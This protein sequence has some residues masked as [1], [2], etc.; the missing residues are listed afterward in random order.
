MGRFIAH[1]CKVLWLLGLVCLFAC[2]PACGQALPSVPPTGIVKE[3]T[4]TSLP[5]PATTTPAGS[6]TPTQ[7]PTPSS[8]LE[9]NAEDLR[10]T[11]I[12]Y[13]H[14][15]SGPAG[16]TMQELVDE[17]NLNNEWRIVVVPVFQDGLERMS[18]SLETALQSGDAP[19]LAMGYLYQALA[20][21]VNQ[22]L[23]DQQIYVD[24][25][26]WGFSLDEQADFY[27]AFWDQD[28]SDGKR[29][30][31]PA[32][33]SG[34]LLYYNQSWAKELGFSF[35]P[36]LPTQ[37]RE[38]ACKAA[39]ANRQ[40]RDPANDG[41]GG[42][43]VS[44]NYAAMLG[45]IYAFGGEILKEPEP[46]LEQSVYQ[47]NSPQNVQTFTFLRE[48]YDDGCAWVA[49]SEFPNAEFASRK[50]LFATD[51][52]LGIPYQVDAFASAGNQ[53]QWTVIPFPSPSQEPAIDVYGPSYVILSSSPERQLAAWLFIK[54]LLLPQ[55]QA[56]IVEASGAFP[57]RAS[58]LSYLEGYKNRHPQWAAALETLPFA[59]SE[60][61]F[62]SWETVRWALSDAGTQL[63]RSY[64]E[65]SQV[66]T[67][68]DFL[69][70][71]AAE[72][73]LGPEVSGVFHTPT[74]TPSPSPNAT[75]TSSPTITSTSTRSPKAS[76]TPTLLV[77]PTH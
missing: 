52:I 48:L 7:T 71:T 54:W 34:Q 39:R 56:R 14:I 9:L 53:D 29:L 62:R 69:D 18:T 41:S 20:W 13:W 22:A 42:W 24:D 8:H 75:P 15:W 28:V 2:L 70:Q 55:N 46:A 65:V 38:Q 33:R 74:N 32:Q 63:F 45:W 72:L 67:L 3:E 26:I 50:G 37:F 31:M 16:K 19:D 10:G 35:P 23:V 64:F 27:P 1:R 40:D 25:P 6:K 66:P 49:E 5:L 30:G 77:S 61:A 43:I 68:L 21:D 12:H 57:L 17:F 11:I 51:S 58:T 59:R 60:P 76:P 36:V 73:Y 47:F 44:T 4:G